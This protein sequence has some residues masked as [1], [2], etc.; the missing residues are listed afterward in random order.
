M[1]SRPQAGIQAPVSLAVAAPLDTPSQ[2]LGQLPL[3]EASQSTGRISLD[4]LSLNAFALPGPLG[5][6]VSERAARISKVVGQFDIVGLQE[7]F[8]GKAKAIFNAAEQAGQ[9]VYTPT[10]RRLTSS[11]LSLLSRFEMLEQDFVPF[12]YAAHADALSQK[13]VAFARVRLPGGQL[14]DVYDTHFQAMRDKDNNRLTQMLMKL[15]GLVLPGFDMPR[16]DIRMHDAEVLM[17]MIQDKDAGHPIFVIGDFNTQ[18]DSAVYAALT[19]EFGL[20]DSFR[21]FNPEDP[22]Y[23]SDGATNPY[24][25]NPNKRKRVDYIFYRPGEQVDIKV[26]SS[27]VVFESPDNGFVLSDHYGVHSRFE[28]IPRDEREDRQKRRND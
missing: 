19:E 11:G 27:E 21:E 28:L 3:V 23:T 14:I 2:T 9:E 1:V 12:K 6:D 17:E 7:G 25:S 22:G 16:D 18:E 24:K 15:T 5:K 13:G 8:S 4:I 10:A 26:E 20:R